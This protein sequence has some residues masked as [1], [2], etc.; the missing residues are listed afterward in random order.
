MAEKC[1]CV[2]NPTVSH[3]RGT[4]GCKYAPGAVMELDPAI[5]E[6][7]AIEFDQIIADDL[8]DPWQYWASPTDVARRLVAVVA[9]LIARATAD[10]IADTIEASPWLANEIDEESDGSHIYRLG[11]GKARWDVMNA[12]RSHGSQAQTTED[13]Q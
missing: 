12:L 5:V 10:A 9:P 7:A 3:R 4:D 6:A 2:G 1:W 11:Y 8:D 13:G